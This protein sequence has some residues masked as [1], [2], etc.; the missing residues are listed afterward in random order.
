VVTQDSF[1]NRSPNKK[2]RKK[3]IRH[4]LQNE[5]GDH[6]LAALQDCPS[7]SPLACY[8]AAGSPFRNHVPSC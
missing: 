3:L 8:L 1:R 5:K 2:C 7:F 6:L 4:F